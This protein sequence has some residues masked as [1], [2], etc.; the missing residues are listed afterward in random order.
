MVISQIDAIQMKVQI[1]CPTSIMKI[2]G[3][4]LETEVGSHLPAAVT[5]RN[6][7]G[8]CNQF[9]DVCVVLL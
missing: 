2:E 8:D 6:P 7:D 4:S 5:L 1:T 9:S 3:L